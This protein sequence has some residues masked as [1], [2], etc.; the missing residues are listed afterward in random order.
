[1]VA[2]N[3][4]QWLQIRIS[5]SQP[6]SL[7]DLTLSLLAFS[8]E[9]AKFIEA[10]AEVGSGAETELLVKEIRP[11]SILVE[12]FAH[13]LPVLP[14]LW[15][16]TPIDAWFSQAVQILDWLAAK[17]ADKPQDMSK[18]DL[19]NW[20]TFIEPIAKDHAS[21]LN[22]AVGDNS[23]VT[24]NQYVYSS[25]DAQKAQE[26]IARELERLDSPADNVHRRKLMH[27]YQTKFVNHT[28]TGDK[29]II[30]DISTSPIKVI[31]ENDAVKAKM[32]AG[33]A[34][35]S[36]P[37]HQLAYVVDV[38]VQTVRGVPKLY[39]ILRYYPDDTI[40]PAE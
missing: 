16:G 28:K 18:S 24:V 30:E 32:L 17:T 25:Q 6:V 14:L 38:E 40:D 8:H 13:V 26:T 5:N 31:F 10:T 7:T 1:M 20:K 11:G 36:R 39:T 22:L 34:D 3:K 12:L 35:F 9:Y 21:Q 37:W 27:W 33:D 19:N 23:T 15:A 4:E 2:V 29:V